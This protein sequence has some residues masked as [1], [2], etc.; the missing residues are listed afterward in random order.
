MFRKPLQHVQRGSDQP[1]NATGQEAIE[2]LIV[3]LGNKQRDTWHRTV[4]VLARIGSLAS[5]WLIEALHASDPLVISGA[6]E[7]LG[8]IGAQLTDERARRYYFDAVAPLIAHANYQ[9]CSSA[10]LAI[11]RLRDPRSL[12]LLTTSWS[13]LMSIY[14]ERAVLQAVGEMGRIA[15]PIILESM[16]S[17]DPILRQKGEG[18]LYFLPPNAIDS[19]V[20]QIADLQASRRRVLIA[21]TR[22][23][24][25]SSIAVLYELLSS[26]EQTIRQVTAAILGALGTSYINKQGIRLEIALR[27]PDPF[28]RL[29]VVSQL[30]NVRWR[31]WEY[32]PV[33]LE[34]TR[35]TNRH[36]RAIAIRALR[37]RAQ[38]EQAVIGALSDK[39][40]C[41]R[42]EAVRALGAWPNP[43]RAEALIGVLH[44][45]ER[46]L[47][48]EAVESLRMMQGEK[49]I[50]TLIEA[51]GSSY[52]TATRR[53]AARAL[54]IKRNSRA[55]TPLLANIADNNHNIRLA[56]A[57]ALSKLTRRLANQEQET[58]IEAL[59]QGLSHSNSVVRLHAA[60]N[61]G[62]LGDLSGE[63]ILT[64]ALLGDEP[65]PYLNARTIKDAL[66]RIH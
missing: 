12:A 42:L 58:A 50:S 46:A 45:P 49:V 13:E 19:L 28:V 20:T 34:L 66:D 44:S 61:L 8:R 57:K 6:L 39:H 30:A 65:T 41:V 54:A 43:A 27:H 62:C 56:A 32:T 24:N 9:V 7:A 47:H 37:G 52:T 3:A 40:L 60:Y 10:Y 4:E 51:L 36:V 59:R 25:T 23:L 48:S 22:N 26:D 5:P 18:A 35:D 14:V 15:I 11:G 17:D 55:V 53:A 31:V 1:N 29:T 63:G 38:A 33:L 2:Q 64:E 16:L 21:R